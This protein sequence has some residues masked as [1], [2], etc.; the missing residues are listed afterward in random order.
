[1]IFFLLAAIYFILKNSWITSGIFFG[2]AIQVKL[3][4][5]MLIP[6]VFKKMGWK[7]SVGFTAMTAFTVLAIGG[8]LLNPEFLGNMMQSVEE[9]FVRFQFNG[10]ISAL[11]SEIGLAINGWDP[12]LTTGP[13]LS[14]I[15]TVGILALAVFKAY[16]NELDIFKGMMFALLIY[17]SMSSIVHPWYISMILVLAIFTHYKFALVWSIVVMLSY[18]AYSNPEFKANP[19][20]QVT[21][22]LCVY[23]VLLVEIWQQ[24]KKPNEGSPVRI[25]FKEF[26]KNKTI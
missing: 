1:M 20:L 12:I 7:V 11:V 6:F 17:Y 21:E 15:A 5:L 22:Y 16:R 26:F 9:Y 14:T 3:I 19:V 13:I 23:L 4:P 18:F 2:L 24:W 10:S 8:I 25:Q